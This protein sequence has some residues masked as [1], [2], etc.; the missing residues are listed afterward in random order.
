MQVSYLR[1]SEGLS[2][3][4]CGWRLFGRSPILMDRAVCHLLRHNHGSCTDADDRASGAFPHIVGAFRD[5]SHPAKTADE[6]QSLHLKILFEGV[7]PM[8]AI[9]YSLHA[10]TVNTV[11]FP[12]FGLAYRALLL[13]A[14]VPVFLG[15]FIL[16]PVTSCTAYCSYKSVFRS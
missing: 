5:L 7:T 2:R 15:Y 8:E 16:V 3:Y 10:Y 11:P 12:L 13:L 9:K 4:G 14:Q 6:S 1:P